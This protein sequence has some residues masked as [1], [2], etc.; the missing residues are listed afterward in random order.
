[1]LCHWLLRQLLPKRILN[2]E[3]LRLHKWCEWRFNVLMHHILG[4][5]H[6]SSWYLVNR[7]LDLA[8]VLKERL[9]LIWYWWHLWSH[10]GRKLLLLLHHLLLRSHHLLLRRHR[11]LI[12]KGSLITLHKRHRHLNPRHLVRWHLA[13]T[14][15]HRITRNSYLLILR[16]ICQWLLERVHH[17]IILIR[18]WCILNT[19]QL[20]S[21]FICFWESVWCNSA[22]YSSQSTFL[23]ISITFFKTS[24]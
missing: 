23:L 15:W 7:R 17:W 11:H 8:K 4:L 1:M 22:P 24:P 5:N 21:L 19:G 9:A 14:H 2:F 18:W 20:T 13:P 16:E 6:R 12:V 3:L 10:H